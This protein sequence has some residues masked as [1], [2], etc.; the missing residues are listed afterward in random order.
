MLP[1]SK[2]AACRG[3][4]AIDLSRGHGTP[5]V[6]SQWLRPAYCRAKKNGACKAKRASGAFPFPRELAAEEAMHRVLSLVLSVTLVSLLIVTAAL[7][8]TGQ[9]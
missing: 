2:M 9:L 4:L 6:P 7:W 1:F 8:I 3:H 5:W